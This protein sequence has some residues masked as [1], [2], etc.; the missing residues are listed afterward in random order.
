[1]T[2]D[3]RQ[4]LQ[5]QPFVPFTLDVADGRSYQISTPE[6]AHIHPSGVR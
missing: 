6:H 5:A 4:R 2:A 3:I 1:M